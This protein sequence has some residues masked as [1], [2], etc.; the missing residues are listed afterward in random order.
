MREISVDEVLFGKQDV[1]ITKGKKTNR[2][3]NLTKCPICGCKSFV[4][5]K[6]NIN[7]F[8][9]G[10][11]I[12]MKEETKNGKK[13]V[14]GML[15]NKCRYN[16]FN[17]YRENNYD[18]AMHYDNGYLENLDI[19][20][21]GCCMYHSY[22]IPLDLDGQHIK[23][24]KQGKH[25][26]LTGGKLVGSALINKDSKEVR[27]AVEKYVQDYNDIV[28]DK[29]IWSWTIV[30]NTGKY[31]DSLLG[32]YGNVYEQAKEYISTYGIYEEDYDKFWE[33]RQK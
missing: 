30:D 2:V 26:N 1:E 33:R 13:S 8:F 15:V 9:C 25:L 24:Y 11:A 6:G 12:Q 16:I 27:K 17:F 18:P 14:Y 31:I 19:D 29:N 3:T 28:V 32:F 20:I 22:D 10:T 21:T 5:V 4:L 7:H 23:I